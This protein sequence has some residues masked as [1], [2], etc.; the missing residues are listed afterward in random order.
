MI[1]ING[2][3]VTESEILVTGSRVIIGRNHVFRFQHPQQAREKRKISENPNEKVVEVVDWN[4]AQCELLEKQ[5]IDLKAE[6]KKRLVVLEAQFKR[7]KEEA[8]HQFEEQRK[9]Y[10]ARIDALQKQVEEQTMTMSIMTNITS[11][12]DMDFSLARILDEY[13]DED[14]YENPLCDPWTNRQ[15]DLAT[16]VF[17]KWKNHQFTSIRDD[18]WGNAIFLKEA[19]SISTELKKSGRRK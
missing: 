6:M 16:W 2:R 8:D 11:A 12:T 13:D 3:K 9:T 1:F 10:E 19:N 4:F 14:I 17:K 7:E 15:L 5:G 18:L